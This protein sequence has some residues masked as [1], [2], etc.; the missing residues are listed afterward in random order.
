MPSERDL[1]TVWYGTELPSLSLRALAS[2]YGVLCAARRGLYRRN[3]LRSVHLPV[4]VIVVGN[5]SVGGAGK[6]PL[7]LALID[8]LKA[9]GFAPGVISRGYRHCGR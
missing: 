3:V 6:T 5:I 4:P 7:T 8:G 9:R 1:R 2:I